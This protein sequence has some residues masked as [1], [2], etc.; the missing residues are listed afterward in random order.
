MDQWSELRQ[1]LNW[2]ISQSRQSSRHT[3]QGLCT[4][5]SLHYRSQTS[6]NSQPQ[7]HC[8]SATATVY[9]FALESSWTSLSVLLRNAATITLTVSNTSSSKLPAVVVHRLARAASPLAPRSVATG[10]P[11]ERTPVHQHASLIIAR[12]RQTSHNCLCY[13]F[14]NMSTNGHHGPQVLIFSPAVYTACVVLSV[15]STRRGSHAAGGDVLQ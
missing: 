2:T 5:Y 3:I 14:R 12:P 8:S 10:T 13:R 7:L 4:L 11:S 9:V 6:R 15:D 1:Q